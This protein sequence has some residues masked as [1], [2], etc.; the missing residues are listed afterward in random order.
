MSLASQ[1]YQNSTCPAAGAYG[2]AVIP[3]VFDKIPHDEKV[4]HI[5]HPF[6][7]I[8]L[9]FQALLLR[10]SRELEI[11]LVATNDIHYTNA[12]DAKPH[13]ILLCIQTAKKLQDEDRM[14]YEG[15][16][17]YVKSPEEM[18]ALFPYFVVKTLYDVT[19]YFSGK[20]GA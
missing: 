11:P 20:A 9:V 3:G 4:V 17:Y 19:L 10:M 7:N 12:E 5:A 6:D 2:N 15:G 16:Q 8:K 18:A 1:S 13:D 14:R